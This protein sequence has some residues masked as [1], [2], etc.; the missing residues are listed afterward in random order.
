MTL[1]IIVV[2]LQLGCPNT[3]PTATQ[4]KPNEGLWQT[5]ACVWSAVPCPSKSDYYSPIN[6][7][8]IPAYC[9]VYAPKIGYPV[10]VDAKVRSDLSSASVVIDGMKSELSRCRSTFDSQLKLAA[11]TLRNVNDELKDC[12][13]V[14]KLQIIAVEDLNS[15]L[16]WTKVF[17]A[18]GITVT[19]ILGVY[20]F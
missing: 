6:T 5:K 14:N 10:S 8:R 15:Q 17:A 3:V 9:K 7:V 2:L 4:L 16:M 13:D 1:P 18:V 11:T 19:A 20:V 12:V